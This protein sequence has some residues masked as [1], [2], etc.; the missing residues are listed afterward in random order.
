VDQP[1]ESEMSKKKYLHMCMQQKPEWLRQCY[2][3]PTA[4]MR[5]IHLKL[6]AIAYRK[7]AFKCR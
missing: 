5:P 3:S 6:I 7:L 1:R 4:Y 2:E